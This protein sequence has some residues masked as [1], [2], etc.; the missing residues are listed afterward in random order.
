MKKTAK[1]KRLQ[2]ERPQNSMKTAN[3]KRLQN[4]KPQNF[5]V[6]FKKKRSL[7]EYRTIFQFQKPQKTSNYCKLP[8]TT[9][10]ITL[11]E[12]LVWKLQKHSKVPAKRQQ[13]TANYYE[14]PIREKPQTEMWNTEKWNT[15]KWNRNLYWKNRNQNNRN[16]K[17]EMRVTKMGVT[18][19]GINKIA[20]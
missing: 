20:L 4:E 6:I 8:Q 7:L 5:L 19:I 1:W 9:N 10:E 17:T 13:S 2:N 18:E 15:T 16:W 11:R 12:K 14:I 3:W